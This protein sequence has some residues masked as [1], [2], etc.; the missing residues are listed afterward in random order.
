MSS[1]PITP[2]ELAVWKT[3]PTWVADKEVARLIAEVERLR[4]ER[5]SLI[6]DSQA[7]G[8]AHV[9]AREKVKRERDQLRGELERA[10]ARV[11]ELERGLRVLQLPEGNGGW[12]S[13]ART[14]ARLSLMVSDRDDASWEDDWVIDAVAC[15]IERVEARAARAEAALSETQ[16]ALQ[17]QR[18]NAANW[19]RELEGW[20]RA[21]DAEKARANRL[22]SKASEF[23]AGEEKPDEYEGE[24]ERS[25]KAL[26]KL[27]DAME[28][29]GV[30]IAFPSVAEELVMTAAI[31]AGQAVLS[32]E[33]K[34]NEGGE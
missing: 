17:E 28:Q 2:E 21:H 20:R 3:E 13:N 10:E 19:Y 24:L 33:T 12:Q 16:L 14:R 6:R 18:T 5:D 34:G 23:I 22:A 25:R 30:T 4:E 11:R 32:A 8:A 31:E 26:R 27:R 7:A 15:E 1:D 9:R 29:P